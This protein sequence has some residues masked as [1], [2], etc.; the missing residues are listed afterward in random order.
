MRKSAGLL[1]SLMLTAVVWVACTSGDTTSPGTES[2]A[3]PL[4]AVTEQCPATFTTKDE[5]GPPWSITAPAGQ[6][7][8]SVCVKAGT[9]VYI[10][11]F[12]PSNQT[13]FVNS[14]PCFRVTGL[15]TP[16]VT[17]RNAA[18]HIGS[19]CKGISHI[20]VTFGPG[21]S[22]SPSPTST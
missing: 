11:T 10:A 5:V 13:I 16:T 6:V 22:P 7:V 4:A 19:I 17:V 15:G 8:A 14:T 1:A 20:V 18:G 2:V 9:Q 3:G 21:P 12:P